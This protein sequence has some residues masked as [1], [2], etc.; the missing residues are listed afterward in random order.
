MTIPTAERRFIYVEAR[1]G[2]YRN[3]L[4]L[5]SNEALMQD[6]TL[7]I[8]C[9]D[10]ADLV[11]Q[12]NCLFESINSLDNDWRK[13]VYTEAIPYMPSFEARIKRLYV[14][15]LNTSHRV[16]ELY[17]KVESEFLSRGFDTEPI[18]LLRKAIREVEGM[19]TDDS[20]FFCSEKLVELRDAAIDDVRSGTDV[21]FVADAV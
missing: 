10:F 1:E 4:E 11:G 5:D 18:H 9:F 21:E 2:S 14:N 6:S 16:V 13:L 12:G 20:V 19:L 7:A 17:G 8:L 15:W 3:Q